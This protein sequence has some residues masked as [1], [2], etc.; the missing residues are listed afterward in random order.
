M[1][2]G[3][4]VTIRKLPTGVPGLDEVLGGGIPEYSFNLIA[5]GPGSG[6]TTLAHQILFANATVER[7]ALYFT[8]LGEPTLKMLRYQQQ[9]RFFD[10]EK[11]GRCIH[12]LN[13]SQVVLEQDLSQVLASIARDVDAANPAFVVVDSFR[14]VTRA[15][16]PGE[17]ELQSFVQRLALLLT[18]WQA[19]SFLV[20]EYVES[21]MRDN[22]VLTVADGILFLTQAVERNSIVRK[23]Q[24]VKMRGQ[25]PVPGLH[26]FRITD[27]GLQ[28]FPRLHV[29]LPAV[30]EAKE[31]QRLPTGIPG[32]DE[33]LGGGI[34]QGDA[35]LVAG[36]SGAGK[37][38]LTTQFIAEGAS[39]GEPGVIAIFEEQI[40]DYLA[41]ARTL[42]FDLDA[43]IRSGDVR[44]VYLRPLDL[45]VDETLYELQER[46]AAVSAKR[47]V[48]DSVAGFEMALAPTF[49]EDFRESL[50]RLVGALT[51]GGMA[52]LLPTEVTESFLDLRFSP[53]LVSFLADDI[54]LLRYV[55][56]EGRLR[57]VIAV[58]KM[59]GSR[60][61]HEI[62][63]FE[64]TGSGLVVGEP[65]RGYRGILS[66]MPVPG[67][68]L[69]QAPFPGLT[70]R[71]M[72]VLRAVTDAEEPTVPELARLTALRRPALTLALDRLVALSYA[73]RVKEG[74]HLV[75][76]RA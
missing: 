8:V 1:S 20:G 44:I 70:D 49:R 22:P 50:Y 76:R 2:N 35:V 28:V 27:D 37:S 75:Y 14:T 31:D 9:F 57:R 69:T 33:M 63:E 19:T 47:V 46:A 30:R 65:L 36:P 25:A 45:S 34:P 11:V 71:E 17:M 10:L 21:E 7:P 56:I 54:I 67:D 51:G 72:L 12:L 60:H 3:E 66:G 73:V 41:N 42:G 5:G 48:V 16:R 18:S 68:G 29:R 62:R 59:R 32:L 43:M 23:L 74:D 38:L 13:L 26:V 58:V 64:I 4:K 15:A 53:H 55:E 39:R 6:K 40:G 52:V 24:V 61:S